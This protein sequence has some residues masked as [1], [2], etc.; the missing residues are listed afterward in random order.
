MDSIGTAILRAFGPPEWEG[1]GL[2]VAERVKRSTRGAV[3][4]HQGNLYP[5]LRLLERDGLLRSWDGETTAERSGRPRRYYALTASGWDVVR[6]L[7]QGSIDAKSPRPIGR[8]PVLVR[9]EVVGMTPPLRYGQRL[10]GSSVDIDLDDKLNAKI[11]RL[12]RRKA[13]H[14]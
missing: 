4:L 3:L 13:A 5:W 14:V 9:G 7:R 8:A 10:R 2:Q 11:I 1:Y 6:P 12:F